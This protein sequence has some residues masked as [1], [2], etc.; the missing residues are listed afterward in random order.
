MSRTAQ[1]A[2]SKVRRDG[3]DETPAAEGRTLCRGTP[4]S[5]NPRVPL[6]T[7]RRSRLLRLRHP[8]RL[9]GGKGRAVFVALKLETFESG[10][11]AERAPGDSRPTF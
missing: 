11:G 4:P 8:D 2:F 3:F 1:R 5:P 9:A 7:M 6:W 10:S